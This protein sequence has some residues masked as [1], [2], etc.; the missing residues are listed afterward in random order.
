M[1]MTHNYIFL[2]SRHKDLLQLRELNNAYLTSKLGWPETFLFS[3]IIKPRFCISLLVLLRTLPS[4]TSL[5]E[6]QLSILFPMLV[7]FWI[8]TWQWDRIL[9]TSLVLPHLL[10]RRSAVS[11]NISID[12]LVKNSFMLS[13]LLARTIVIV[14][15]STSPIRIFANFNA[16]KTHLPALLLSQ[17]NGITSPQSCLTSTGC[18]SFTALNFIKL[19]SS[20]VDIQNSLKYGTCLNVWHNTSLCS[21]KDAKIQLQQSP[22]DAIC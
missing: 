21:C 20:S 11:E 4:P 15:S 1:L 2:W 22:P 8:L 18:L 5:Q 16:S 3:T 14:Y 12:S 17:K 10:W 13:Y 7:L 19:Q 6:K 9:I